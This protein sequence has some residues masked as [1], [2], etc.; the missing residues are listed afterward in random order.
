M[1]RP[2]QITFRDIDPIESVRA[3]VEERVA[4]LHTFHPNILSCRVAL[5]GP[6]R[7]HLHGGHFRVRLDI[8]IPGEEVVVGRDAPDKRSHEN[9]YAA[10]DDAVENMKRAL[11]ERLRRHR[12]GA[13]REG[14][15]PRFV[16]PAAE[17]RAEP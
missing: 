15:E 16:A 10:I 8:A 4:K 5:E 1:P 7:H 12:D 14:S 3:Y 11:K 9:L 13:R 2:I 17:E 6:H